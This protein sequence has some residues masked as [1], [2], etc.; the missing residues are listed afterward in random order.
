MQQNIISETS[1]RAAAQIVLS[2]SLGRRLHQTV[3]SRLVN[4][5]SGSWPPCPVDVQ[6]VD[7]ALNFVLCGRTT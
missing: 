5:A 2:H 6:M 3:R 7:R 4:L 1:T